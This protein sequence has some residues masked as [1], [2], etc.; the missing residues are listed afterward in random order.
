MPT[1]TLEFFGVPRARA[2]VASLSVEA[3][4]LGT[5]LVAAGVHLPEFATS[6]LDGE[7]LKPAYLACIN[8]RKFTTDPRTRLAAGDAVL[9]L[10]A[11]AGG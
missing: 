2:G 10:S 11:D 4:E 7:Q 6:C 3:N 9:I 5:A 8:G 1:V